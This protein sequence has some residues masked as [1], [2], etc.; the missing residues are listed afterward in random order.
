MPNLKTFTYLHRSV[1]LSKP[2]LPSSFPPPILPRR[3]LPL[4]LAVAGATSSSVST[5]SS[6]TANMPPISVVEHVVLFKVRESTDPSLTEAMISNLRSLASLGIASY[7]TAGPILRRRSSAAEAFGFTHLLFSRYSSKADLATYSAHPSHLAVVKENVF[8]IC[9][10][11]MA[12]D[13]IAEVDVDAAPLP[14]SLA[15]LT[16]AKPRIGTAAAELVKAIDGIRGSVP[17]SVQVSYGENFSPARAKGY[18]VGFISVFPG[19]DEAEAIEGN[20]EVEKQK[21]KV[22]PLLESAVV[23]DYLVPSPVPCI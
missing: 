12:V 13:W 4:R 16:L 9:D 18:E 10:D 23:L 14:G 3:F 21:E 15:R 1:S 7:L 2:L 19:L 5:F 22:R 6:S 8:P 20:E 17:D 11:V